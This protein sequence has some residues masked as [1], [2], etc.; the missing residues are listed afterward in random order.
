MSPSMFPYTSPAYI[1]AIGACQVK[2]APKIVPKIPVIGAVAVTAAPATA[3]PTIP[4]MY[5][6]ATPVD[7]CAQS[8]K[9]PKFS[10]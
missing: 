3:E 5:G 7:V 8:T 6:K 9:S 1:H 10:I 2:A 4:N